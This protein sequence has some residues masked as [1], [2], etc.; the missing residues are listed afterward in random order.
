V[1]NHISK[2]LA[3][4]AAG[5]LRRAEAGGAWAAPNFLKFRAGGRKKQNHNTSNILFSK[6]SLRGSF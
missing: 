6:K 4:P 3:V 2:F 5:C 1:T